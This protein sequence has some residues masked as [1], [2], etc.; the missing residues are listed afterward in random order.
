MAARQGRRSILTGPGA[1][2]SH[3]AKA[4]RRPRLA[5]LRRACPGGVTACRSCPSRWVSWSRAAWSTVAALASATALAAAA[6]T[7]TLP[8]PAQQFAHSVIGA[9][10]PQ[11]GHRPGTQQVTPARTGAVGPDATGPAAFGL[12]TAYAHAEDP[13]RE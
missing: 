3:A 7:G 6:Y 9:P 11:P 5:T 1:V 13:V 2:S 4:S 10:S 8:A 12:C